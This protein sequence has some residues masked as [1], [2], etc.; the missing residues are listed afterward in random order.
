MF[1]IKHLIDFVN[2]ILG[3]NSPTQDQKRMCCYILE[4][5]LQKSC[6]DIKFHYLKGNYFG[7]EFDRFYF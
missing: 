1:V 2:E 7:Q 5:M 4:N 3:Q 6:V